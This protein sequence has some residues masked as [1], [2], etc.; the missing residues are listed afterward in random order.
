MHTFKNQGINKTSQTHQ[1]V[2]VVK[3]VHHNSPGFYSH[4]HRYHNNERKLALFSFW[5]EKKQKKK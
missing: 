1:P 4:G 3:D 2:H 5:S